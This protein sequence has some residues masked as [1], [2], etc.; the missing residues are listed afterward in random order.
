MLNAIQGV[1]RELK[2]VTV[3]VTEVEARIR[4]NQ[5]NISS[6]Q[7][8]N[9]DLIATMEKLVLKVDNF[10]IHSRHSNL[11]LVG[12]PKRTEGGN[13]CSFLE[14]WLIDVFGADNF[15]G[16]PLLERAHRIW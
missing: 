3:R 12:L 15:P 8:Q 4:T 5:D 7:P 11:C 1:R 10:E 13:L 9:V 14:K 16:P 6:L 2:V